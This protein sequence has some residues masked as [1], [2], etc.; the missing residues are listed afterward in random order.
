[1]PK[2][3]KVV[4]PTLNVEVQATLLEEQAPL[5]CDAVW[6]AL[7]RP[8]EGSCRHGHDTGPE[9]Y[10]LMP[11]APH[12]PD[13]NSTL[14]PIPGDFLF[15]HYSGQLPRGEKVYDIGMYYDRGGA[16]LLRIGWTPGNLFATVTENLAGLQ[17][18]AKEIHETGPKPIRVE[19]VN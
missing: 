13:E 18:V 10:V 19:R 16:S 7:E 12:L 3:I 14:F 17:R 4:F 15:Y 8:I 6:N 5:T 1:L 2:A 9:L 11:P